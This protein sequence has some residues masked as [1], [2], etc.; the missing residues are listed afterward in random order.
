MEILKRKTNK[1]NYTLT[2]QNKYLIEYRLM[3]GNNL[4]DFESAIDYLIQ[5]G[6][7]ISIR[8]LALNLPNYLNKIESKRT[9]RTS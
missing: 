8:D 4:N 9:D 3:N 1:K 7:T 5:Q 6:N 2:T